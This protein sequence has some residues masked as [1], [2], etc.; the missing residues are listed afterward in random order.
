MK[1]VALVSGGKDSCFNILRCQQHGHEV[2]ALANLHPHET[3]PDELDSFCFQ[4]VGHQLLDVYPAC[5]GLPLYRLRFD[6]NSIQQ[7]LTYTKCEGDEVEDLYRLIA[8]VLQQHPEVT[9]VSSGAIASDYQ[10]LRVEHVCGRLALTSLAYLWHQPQRQLLAVRS[11]Q[12]HQIW[13][14]ALWS[15]CR[16]L[17]AGCGSKHNKQCACFA[18]VRCDDQAS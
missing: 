14:K 16:T 3:A 15:A 9:A 1:V 18:H 12:P 6:G 7:D 11:L 4:T 8:C 5:T 13:W 10:R 2:V 17:Q